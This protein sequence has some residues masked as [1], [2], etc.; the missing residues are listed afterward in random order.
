MII[1]ASWKPYALAVGFVLAALGGGAGSN[2]FASPTVD[3]KVEENSRRL[4]ILETSI[5]R[6]SINTAA[7][8]CTVVVKGTSV[9][10][11]LCQLPNGSVQRLCNPE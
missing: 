9:S 8:T 3:A 10:D 5:R 1:P 4:T 7:I 11:C 2:L 6:L